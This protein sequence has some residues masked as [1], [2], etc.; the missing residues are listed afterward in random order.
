MKQ[1]LPQTRDLVFV[2]GGH[3]H[4]LVLRSWAMNPLPGVRV[5]VINPGPTAP[6]SGMLPG[7]VAGHY[8]RADLD[9]DLVQLARFA[10]ARVVLGYATH[11]DVAQKQIIV[12]GRP[13]ISYDVA[14][15]DVGITSTMPSLPGFTDH[16]I[17]AKPLG[18]FA[19]RWDAFRKTAK[20]PH[21]AIIGGGVAGA[22]LSMAMAHAL[23]AD[24]SEQAVVQLVDR[25]K[26]LKDLG[27]TAKQ[28]IL[29][30]LKAQNVTLIE[31][32]DVVAI[33]ADGLRLSDGRK[34]RSDFTNGAAGAKPHDWV[35]ALALDIHE[36]FITVNETLQSSDPDL[37]AVGDCAHLAFDPRPKAGVYAVREAPVLFD[38]LRAR[39]S[40]GKL[41]PYKPQKDYLKL[42]SLGGKSAL[43]EKFGTA[44]AGAV[45]WKLKNH[46]DQTFM[47]QFRDLPAMPQP[48]LP[49]TVADGLRAALGDKPMCGGCGSKVGR[50]TLQRALATLPAQTRKDVLSIPGDDAAILKTGGATQVIST[51]HLRALVT[52]PVMMTRI[53]AVHALGDVWAMGAQPQ[54]ATATII[55]PRLA[56]ALQERTLA[57]MMTTAHEVF[58]AAGAAIVGGHSSQGDELTVGF[59]V[60]GLAQW[61]PITLAGAQPGAALILTKPIGSGVMM[62]AE[63]Q[64]KAPGADVAAALAMMVQPQGKASD[65][66][67]NAQAMTDVTGF[68]LAGHLAGICEASGVGAQVRLGDV[69]VMQGARDLAEAGIQSSLLAENRAGATGVQAPQTP[70]GDLMFDPQTAGGLL[71]AVPGEQAKATL[72]ALIAAGYPAAIIGETTDQAGVISFTS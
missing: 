48:D 50:A 20:D 21:I 61:H 70:L 34:I 23:R 44:R 25:G 31:D 64:S 6:Y 30:A 8:Q 65:I 49:L 15:V 66:L 36:G 28:K 60:T 27:V 26:V 46:I 13:P 35:A 37:F 63:M 7:F 71:A 1:L 43:A 57:E 59:T 24:G 17:P 33:E 47:Q 52:D 68:G 53:A 29:A 51:D 58:E 69:P 9:I 18:T 39:L 3:T 14:A 41:R 4:A 42:I 38:N 2:G 10:G 5:T 32:A 12:P 40:G 45:L 22:E 54:A 56:P 16:A 62:A 19:S 72:A 55:L 67:K 11:I